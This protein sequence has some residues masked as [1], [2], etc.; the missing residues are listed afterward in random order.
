M[1]ASSD[2]F[3]IKQYSS[4]N[5]TTPAWGAARECLQPLDPL[6]FLPRLGR[7][8]AELFVPL[9]V[10]LLT[11]LAA[12]PHRLA[13]AAA[14]VLLGSL[15]EFGAGRAAADDAVPALGTALPELTSLLQAH[16]DVAEVLD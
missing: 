2:P 6:R 13:L 14:V 15:C 11:G 4:L 9:P 5:L 12:V 16:T 10:L 1:P 7:V 8:L 3:Y